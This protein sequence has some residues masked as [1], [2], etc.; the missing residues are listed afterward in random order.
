MGLEILNRPGGR[1]HGHGRRNE[2]WSDGSEAL[3]SEHVLVKARYVAGL[4]LACVAFL[5]GCASAATAQ[6]SQPL[7]T[8][9][10]MMELQFECLKAKGWDVKFE[11]NAISGSIPRA[12]R[13]KYE[14]DVEVC[15]KKAGFDPNAPLTDAVYQQTYDIYSRI[16]SCLKEH[17]WATPAKPSL[18]AFKATYDSAPWIPWSEVNGPDL[19]KATALC[20][21][22]NIK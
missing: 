12:Q 5:T 21:S 7:K 11:N 20:P 1:V 22:M 19:E 6:H 9:P 2:W 17:G 8:T 15:L 10:H 3:L 18:A 4:T 13:S 16:A 14:S